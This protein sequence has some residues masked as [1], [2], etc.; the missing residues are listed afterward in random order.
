MNEI[1]ETW[2]PIIGYESRYIISNKGEVKSLKRNKLL[3]KELRR[4][5]WSVQLYN[6]SKFK[7]FSIHRLVGIHFIENPNNLPF[8]NHID[9]NKLN[10]NANNL[11]WCTASY[12]INY[13]TSIQRAIEKKSIPVMQ[14]DKNENLINIFSSIS[15][16]ESKTKI[17]NPNIVKCCK[18][19]RK[20]AGGYIWKYA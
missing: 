16:A 1:N 5:Y 12:N 15:E 9:E 10:N 4:N 20:T 8:I 7:H 6:G 13:G 3:K 11:E 2:K 18:G 17:Y 14:L 19:E